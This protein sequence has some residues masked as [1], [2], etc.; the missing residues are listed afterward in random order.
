[1]QL[2]P[3]ICGVSTRYGVD[4]SLLFIIGNLL[5]IRGGLSSDSTFTQVPGQ[6]SLGVNPSA[7][8]TFKQGQ[9]PC[10]HQRPSV[11]SE[12]QRILTPTIDHDFTRNFL[13]GRFFNQWHRNQ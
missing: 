6:L 7:D 1:M 13:H 4:N 3:T 8:L 12:F 10:Q 9:S 2:A 11:I 5:Q